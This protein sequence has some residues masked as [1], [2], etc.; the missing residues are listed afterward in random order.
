M[1][2]KQTGGSGAH[3]SITMAD[4]ARHAGVSPATVSRALSGNRPVASELLERVQASVDELGYSVNLVGRALRKQR[5]SIVG[6]VVPDFGNPFFST[7]AHHLSRTFGPSG[8]EL[9]LFGGDGS[10]ETELRGVRS[11]IGR[12]VDALVLVPVHE[13]ES[14]AAVSLATRSV[15]TV[16]LDRQVPDLGAHF[17]G[18][19]NREGMRLVADHVREQVDVADQPVVFVGGEPTSSSGHE[20]LD[21]FLEHFPE[22]PHHLGDFSTSWGQEAV[23]RL[24][25]AGMRRGTIVT[26]ADVIAI[27]AVSAIQAAGHSVPGDF[28]VTGFDGIDIS[29]LVHPSLTTVRQ[30][31]EAMASAIH[32]LVEAELDPGDEPAVTITQ[33][34]PELVVGRSSPGGAA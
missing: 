9:L 23:G 25:A 14:A 21:G 32:R 29:A 6:M 26:G 10:L 19:D 3:R 18:C 13:V 27:G 8:T 15:V 17:I 34:P 16:Q 12:Q 7:L 31:F 30:P 20:R 28:R 2:T 22:V 5:S 24:L 11:F 33:H 4:V 1:N